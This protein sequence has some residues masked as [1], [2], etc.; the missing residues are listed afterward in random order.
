MHNL[1]SIRSIINRSDSCIITHCGVLV[2][3]LLV[4]GADLAFGMCARDS[5]AVGRSENPRGLV[6]MWWGILASQPNLA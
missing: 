3:V 1:S 2:L 4:S 5:R 6:L